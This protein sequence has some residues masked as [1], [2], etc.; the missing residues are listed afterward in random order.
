[1]HGEKEQSKPF[2]LRIYFAHGIDRSG[3]GKSRK[4]A[5]DLKSSY[6]N[7]STKNP[8]LSTFL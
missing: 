8:S 2:T 6:I 4:T 1:M 7:S 3:D 5:S